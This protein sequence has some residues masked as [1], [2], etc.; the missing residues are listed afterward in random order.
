[1]SFLWSAYVVDKSRFIHF[2]SATPDALSFVKNRNLLAVI[3]KKLFKA[4]SRIQGRWNFPWISGNLKVSL[5]II[6]FRRSIQWTKRRR[7]WC[8]SKKVC[9]VG[10]GVLIGL[11]GFYGVSHCFWSLLEK[12]TR[13]KK[14]KRKSVSA[15]FR[16][17]VFPSGYPWG[18]ISLAGRCETRVLEWKGR[19]PSLHSVGSWTVHIERV[20]HVSSES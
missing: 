19:R 10:Y 5:Q 17:P 6:N 3:I 7:C 9:K 8:H 15:I 2:S 1:M 12:T 16:K 4:G 13:L 20:E 18:Q 14:K 11:W